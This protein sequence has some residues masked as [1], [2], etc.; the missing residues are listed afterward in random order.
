MDNR[1]L[2]KVKEAAPALG[3]CSASIY[4]MVRSGAIPSVKIGK[5]VRLRPE[6]VESIRN[7]LPEG[8]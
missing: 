6:T 8:R 2:I 1:P 4:R 7:G 5:A 3:L